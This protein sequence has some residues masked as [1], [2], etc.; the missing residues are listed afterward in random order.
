MLSLAWRPAL[1]SLGGSKLLPFKNGGGHCVPEDLQCCRNVLVPFPRSVPR[2]NPVSELYG[3]SLRPHGLVFAPTCTVN[4]GVLYRQVHTHLSKSC[5]INLIYHRWTPSCRN[6]SRMINGNR[7]HQSSVS[8]L[9]AKGLNT[10]LNKVFLVFIFLNL[11]PSLFLSFFLS[12]CLSPSLSPSLS[13]PPR[14]RHGKHRRYLRGAGVRSPG[15]HLHGGAGVYVVSAAD[16]RNRGERGLFYLHLLCL[17]LPA[18]MR[19]SPRP[20][21]TPEAASPMSPTMLPHTG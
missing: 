3:Q 20:S 15:G 6:I 5:P 4:C 11:F 21:S 14:T 12:L 7:M 9:I 2:H 13:L 10:Y 16:A 19:S 8:G 17:P 18:L 1:G